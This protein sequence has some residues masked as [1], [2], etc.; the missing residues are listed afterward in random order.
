MNILDQITSPEQLRELSIG[1]MEELAAEIREFLLEKVSKTGGHLASNLGAVELTLALHRV[2][3]TSRDRIVFDVGHQSYVHKLLT[4][5]RE[6]FDTLRQFGG[7]SGFPKPSES[8]HDAFIAGHASN[9]VSVALGMARSRSLLGEDYAVAA[10]IGDGALSGGLAYEGLSNAGASHES[11]VVVLNDNEMSISQNVGGISRLLSRLRTR[12]GYLHFK[13][14]YRRIMGSMPGL[15]AFNHRVKESIKRLLLPGNIFSDLGF[16]YLG[17]VD[18]HD[19]RQLED[20]LIMAREMNCPVLLH[21]KTV[22]GKGYP[23]AEADPAAYHGVGPFDLEKGVAKGGVG[24][25]NIFGE[26]L[27]ELA[28]KNEKIVAIT[29]AMCYGTGLRPF[30]KKFPDRLFDVGIAEEHGVSMAA[31]LAK[32]GACPVFAVY[33]SFLQ[34]AYDMLIHDVSLLGLHVVLGVDRAGLVGSDGETHHGVFDVSFLRSVPYMTV[35]CP[36]SYA[37]LRAMLRLAVERIETPV[38]LRYPR[39]SEGRYTGNTSG[40]MVSVFGEGRDAAI[41]VYG[42]MMNQALEAA[43][44]LHESGLDTRIIKINVINP[45][46]LNVVRAACAPCAAVVVAEDV[47]AAGCVGADIRSCRPDACLLNLGSGI[48]SQGS[49]SQ[50]LHSCGLD[51][52]GIADAVI[53]QLGEIKNV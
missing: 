16:Y 35:L 29:A 41:V 31:G 3:D 23:P 21:V 46:D 34:R 11:M 8:V 44:L 7:L 5:R 26:T 19:L 49:V 13:R 15:Y 32:Q 42:N 10:V 12:S 40:R 30:S 43:D 17:P 45:L 53:K 36:S 2:Y 37:E 33:S 48:V 39:G 38:A 50:L 47:C 4:G 52:R 14:N 6:K 22:K 9:S 24:Y 1:E 20:A 18:G 28:R 51:G 27:C 25:S